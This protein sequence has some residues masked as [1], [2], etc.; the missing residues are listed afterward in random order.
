MSDPPKAVPGVEF[1]DRT[2][3]L[4]ERFYDWELRGRGW[5]VWN[6]A[7]DI[8]PPFRPVSFEPSARA[9]GSSSLARTLAVLE[10]R[11][12]KRFEGWEEPFANPAEPS[13]A[14]VHFPLDISPALPRQSNP[15]ALAFL[16]KHRELMAFEIAVKGPRLHAQLSTAGCD[17]SEDIAANVL[18]SP[19]ESATFVEL[20]LAQ[21]FLVPLPGDATRCAR[22]LRS[23][24]QLAEDEAALL[25]ILFKATREP[26]S[27]EM[28]RAA[29]GP[30]GTG[31]FG[32][33]DD[34]VAPCLRKIGKSLYAVVVR[35]MGAA[36]D[37]AQARTIAES[38]IRALRAPAAPSAN[39]LI[40]LPGRDGALPNEMIAR[41]SRRSGMILNRDELAS[42]VPFELPA[43][44]VQQVQDETK[45]P[46][47][48]RELASNAHHL[49]HRQIISPQE[50]LR[51][52][53]MLARFAG[54][55]LN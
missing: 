55:P 54:L 35:V 20:G 43:D 46:I 50:G 14:R 44:A 22:V 17:S 39:A 11:Q 4:T 49:I 10:E 23:L 24:S 40:A 47:R 36:P 34:L 37:A 16:E 48:R 6:Y 31:L 30:A 13:G 33:Q 32:G 21:E 9:E 28:L 5:Q 2:E 51:R 12:A 45:V 42:L 15:L 19:P 26:W 53:A 8:E 25:Q 27:D 38:V 52:P 3:I 7:V 18:R 1:S 41:T 29:L